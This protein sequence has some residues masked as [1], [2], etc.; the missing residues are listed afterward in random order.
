[1]ADC[2]NGT[3]R[4]GAAAKQENSIATNESDRDMNV[5]FEIS[6]VVKRPVVLLYAAEGVGL[7]VLKN[8]G[9]EYAN[10]VGGHTCQ[11]RHV[12]GLY[13]PIAAATSKF[14]A[15]LERHFQTK[16]GS[17]EGFDIETADF[18]DRLIAEHL[19]GGI[20]VDRKLVAES[21]EAWVY[22]DVVD[23]EA[24]GLAAGLGNC[25]AVLTWPNSD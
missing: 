4:A 12:E 2:D 19:G 13:V 7:I 9:V 10:Q 3:R 21:T 5:A 8:S 18:I 14:L 24:Q 17:W 6:K 23:S 25:K 16:W 22:V 11:Q 1:M 20:R 15:E